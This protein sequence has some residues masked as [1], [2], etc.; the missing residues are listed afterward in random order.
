M[1][2]PAAFLDSRLFFDGK[3][4]TY[5][6][7]SRRLGLHVDQ[8]KRHLFSFHD[9]HRDR[10]V[11]TYVL[12]GDA[13]AAGDVDMADL[14]SSSPT[15]TLPDESQAGP[16]V[17]RVV[18]LV[19]Q[20]ELEGAKAALARVSSV[21]VYSLQP[22]ETAAASTD[23]F[24]ADAARETREIDKTLP[25]ETLRTYGVITV[26]RVSAPRAPLGV[27]PEPEPA[28]VKSEPRP[29]AV[30]TEPKPEPRPE[31]AP[32]QKPPAKAPARKGLQSMWAEP[33]AKVPARPAQKTVNAAAALPKPNPKKT[34][35]EN[36][37]PRERKPSRRAPVSA[38]LGALFDDDAEPAAAAAERT[39]KAG[40]DEAGPAA[41]LA[42][43][44]A[45]APAAEPAPDARD[46][47][48]FDWEPTPEPEEPAPA[49]AP[50]DVAEPAA[51]AEPLPAQS[52]DVPADDHKRGRR[53]VEREIHDTDAQGFMVT[54]YVTE[55]ESCSEPE[56]EPQPPPAARPPPKKAP[57]PKKN[58]SKQQGSLMSFWKK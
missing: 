30:K 38:Q 3:L 17:T 54:R 41:G 4:V 40:A 56:D 57:G 58:L 22:L 29:A 24:L 45:A 47:E 10:L 42:A 28:T 12:T 52:P 37:Q 20:N 13:P 8:A 43:E 21:H 15:G 19:G 53:R 51:P 32:E 2:D 33:Q 36:Q 49:E 26:D 9:A 27:K 5:G 55:W 6:L 34:N 11:A 50:E 23:A 44:P 31:P 35:Q 46:E 48:A 39:A 16:A 7:L 18:Q 25:A 1:D 14:P